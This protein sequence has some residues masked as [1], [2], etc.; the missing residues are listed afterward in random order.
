M[1]TQQKSQLW[2]R[3][4]TSPA[5][6]TSHMLAVPAVSAVFDSVDHII[7]LQRLRQSYRITGMIYIVIAWQ[8]SVCLVWDKQSPS[9]CVHHCFILG[10][11][12]LICV[13][14]RFQ[15]DMAYVPTFTDCLYCFFLFFSLFFIITG[16]SWH[17]LRLLLHPF[18]GL[19]PGQ[20]G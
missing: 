8:T 14:P 10:P 1:N 18:N 13:L 15:T 4:L 2:K 12:L 19:F 7:L 3:M 11:L 17:S 20:P 5:H 16:S 6:W 9:C